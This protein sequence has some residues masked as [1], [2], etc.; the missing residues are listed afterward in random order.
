M[1]ETIYRILE[2]FVGFYCILLRILNGN[3]PD[4]DL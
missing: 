3:N 1:V 4:H 2:Y